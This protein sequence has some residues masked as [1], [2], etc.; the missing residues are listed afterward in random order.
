[1]TYISTTILI[2][3]SKKLLKLQIIK[4]NYLWSEIKIDGKDS[5]LIFYASGKFLR[6]IKTNNQK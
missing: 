1:L 5:D 6:L 3:K 4:G 2:K